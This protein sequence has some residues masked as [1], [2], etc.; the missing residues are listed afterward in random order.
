MIQT[1]F[2]ARVKIQQI[3]NNQLPE[4][5]LDESPKAAEF[6]KQYYISQEF[7][8]ASVDL[9]ENLD[10]YIK[11]DNLTPE[12]IVGETTL[13]QS[14]NS[15]HTSVFVESTKGFPQS[16]GLFKIDDEIIT[17]TGI[18]TNS[19]TGCIRGFSGITDYHDDLKSEELVFSTSTANSH[20]LDSTVINLSSLFLQ[21]I[22]KKLKYSLTPGLENVDFVS[23]LNVGNFIK[24]ARS[25]YESKGTPESFRILFN[26]LFGET[27]KVI[28]LEQFLIKP[29]DSEY[30]RREVVAVEAISGDPTQLEGQSIFK[31]TD[32][33]TSAS[34]SE[35]E[36]ITRSGKTYY[37]LLLFLGY[38][39]TYPT[40]TGTFTITPSSKVLSKVS[41]G[42]SVI[43]VDST[44]G[45]SESGKVYSGNNEITYTN[46]T[47][48]Q[49][50][51]CSGV[52][53]EIPTAAVIRS[54]ETYYGYEN[55][56]LSKKVE[57]RVTGVLSNTVL[58]D[59]NFNFIE[60]D[61]LYPLNLG[62]II[63]N[64]TSKKHLFANTWIYNTS[65]RHQIESRNGTTIT[66]KSPV[67][68]SN[69]KVGDTLE[70]LS[71]NSEIV[72]I[73]PGYPNIEV[74]SITNEKQISTN[75]PVGSIVPGEY[76]IRRKIKTASSSPVPIEFGN[77]NILSDVLNVYDENSEYLYVA[78]NSL[79]SY[80]INS[81][82]FKYTIFG[83][84]GYNSETERYS[85]ITF[86]SEVS[87]ITGDSVYYD[88]SNSSIV[89]LERGS[90]FVEVLS[91]NTSIRLY[92]SASTI[93]TESY[94]T[95]TNIPSGT[96]TLVL[97]SQKSNK[98]SPQKILKK[99][100]IQS[101][102]GDTE[103]NFT[104][105]GAT[106]MLKNGVE[107][108]NYK[109]NDKVYYGPLENVKVLNGGRD[110]D[111][112][113]SPFVTPSFGNALL[114]PVVIGSVKKVYIDP[115]DFN[116]DQI[117]SI[118][119]TG[120][121]GRGASFS[122]VVEKRRREIE[123]DARTIENGGGLDIN[124]E[125][126]VFTT[127]H[128]LIN[129]QEVIY[130]NNNFPEIGVG[131]YKGTNNNQGTT[132]KNG[133]SYFVNTINTQ[134]I[135][136][137]SQ[138]SDYISGINTVGF[139]TI[140]NGGI[141]KLKTGIKNTLTAIKVINGGEGYA[142]RLLRVTS[143]GIST[144]TH[145]INFE[146]HGFLNGELVTY[147]YQ[148][149]AISGLSTSNQYYIL[150]VDS[151]S[152]RVCNAGIGGT[153]TSNYE[154][155]N[156]VKF[157]SKGSGYQIF[158]YP[159][160]SLEVKYTAV[161]LGSTQVL[162]NIVATPVVTGEISQVYAYE[163]G[164][165]YGSTII[166]VHQRPSILVK[167]GSSAQLLPIISN[168]RIIDV[169]IQFGGIEYYSTPELTVIGKGSGATL[170]AIISNN[171]IV[172][173]IIITPGAGYSQN[174]TVIN[175]ES[176]G[177]NSVFQSNV[178]SLTLNSSYKYGVQNQYYR[179]PATEVLVGTNNNLQYSVIGY[180]DT[181]KTGINDGGGLGVG[182]SPI[183]GWS[184]DGN[185]I[186]GPYG[187]SD[188]NNRNSL[189]KEIQPGYIQKSPTN[190]PSTTIFPIDS[191]IEDYEYN[192]T[193][194]LDEYNGRFTK[195]PEF[196][197]GVYA[198]FTTIRR[199]AEGKIVGKFPYFIGN[200]YRS[201]LLTEN[202][203]LDQ[204]FDFNNSS[205]V[206]NTLPYKVNDPFADYD[207]AVESNEIVNQKTVVE[208]VTS[209]SV[210]DLKIISSG[211]DYLIGDE[212]VFDDTGTSGG[213]LAANVLEVK[214]KD[215]I[216]IKTSI[217]SNLNSLLTWESGD[218]IKVHITPYHELS[219]KDNII[220]S[221]LTTESTSLNGFY[222][223]GVSS[224]I[225][226]VAN[227]IPNFTTTVTD[228]YITDIP[229]NVSIGSSIQIENEV[230]SI[231]NSYPT[232]GVLRVSRS[233]S[234][235]AHTQTTSV[236]FLTDS[237]TIDKKIPYFDS[238]KNNKV[239]FNPQQSIGVGTLPGT[240]TYGN[241]NI[242]ITTYNVFIPTQS[243]FLPGH[244]FSNGEEV[245]LRRI[246]GTSIS[247]SN[248]SGGSIFSIL[249]TETE[250]AYVI[251]KS[252]DFIGIVTNIGLTTTTSGVFFLSN[253]SDNYF[254][255]I[256]TNYKQ[257]RADITRV[258]TVV[259]VS[260]SHN[261]NI[262]DSVSLQVNPNISVGIGTSTSVNVKFDTNTQSLIINPIIFTS[263]G[264]STSLDIITISNHNL[265]NGDKVVYN[266]TGTLATGL[267]KA[268]YYVY[269]IDKDRISL[270]QTY[271]DS[272]KNP[273]I[274]V[275][276]T[277]TGS[278]SHSL[279]L[280]NPEI[281][282]I[283]NNNL[284]FNLSDS[285]LQ[286][287]NFKIYYDKKFTKEFL[288]DENTSSFS[289]IGVGTV[290]VTP[291]AT[292]TLN[293]TE[294]T[295]E[296]LYYALEKSGF[297]STS[298]TQV[299]NY[300]EIVT[301][302]SDYNGIYNVNGVGSTNFTI[303]LRN[304][305]ERLSYSQNECDILEYSTKSTN[306]LGGVHRLKLSS[307]G[308]AYRKLPRFDGTKSNTGS[309]LF[310]LPI[311]NQIGKIR[312]E[313]VVNEGFEYASDKTLR[314][315]I[316]IPN[317]L[318]IFSANT[319]DTIQVLDG[320]QNYS[321]APDLIC[322]DSDTGELIDS[323]FIKANLSGS[324]INSVTIENKPR[325]LPTK[326]VTIRAINNT[327]GITINQVQYSSLA[328]I[329]TCILVTPILGFTTSPF[330]NGEKIY[331]EGIQKYDSNGDGFNSSD[332]GYQ[333][334]TVYN[335]F[336]ND[337][338]LEY[339]ISGFTT[340]AGIAKTIQDS[341]SSI[342][343][344]S[345]YPQFQVN[346]VFSPFSIGEKLSS[347]SGFGFIERDLTVVDS[348]VNSVRV[349]GSYSL[350]ENEKIRGID[351]LSE[352]TISSQESTSGFYN[353]NYSNTQNLG[354]KNNIGKL[355][356]D[357]QVISD[358]DYYQ[359][360]SYTVKSSKTWDEI[361]SPVN[362]IV[363]TSGLKNF[364]DLQIEELV[365]FAG[366][367]STESG[368]T[369]IND[370]ISENRVDTIH[371]FDLGIDED[372]SVDSSKFIKFQ[373]IRL[374]DYILC[375]TNLVLE[376]DDI[377]SEF[378][379]VDE[380]KLDFDLLYNSTPIFAKTF[381]PT[382]S[383]VVNL[384]TGRFTIQNHFFSTGEELIYTP[385][386]TGSAGMAIGATA[387][388]LG[389]TTTILPSKVWAIK[390]SNDIFRLSTRPEYAS[391]GIGVTFTS[392]GIGNTHQVEMLKKNEKSIITINNLAQYPISYSAITH[393]L[394]GN[395]GQISTSKTIFG[396]SGITSIFLTDILKIDNEYMRVDNVGFGT[397][398]S[399]PISFSGN[400]PL[401]EVV[402]GFLG[403]N[404]AIHTDTSLSRV[405]RGAYNI[406][407]SK[408]FFA[409][410]PVGNNI[411]LNSS[412]LPEPRDSFTGR[413]F[414]RKN[415]SS[416]LVYDDV[417]DQFT[418]LRQTFTLTTQGIN[419]TGIG[420][421]GGNGIVFINNIFQTPSTLNNPANNYSI[422]ESTGISS[423][424]FSGISSSNGNLFISN[425]DVNQNDLPRGGIIVS[426]GSTSGLGYAPLVGASVTAIVSG[427]SIVSIGI[428]TS[429]T[430]GSGYRNPVSVAV[431][432]STGN[433]AI[434]QAVAGAGG[435]VI[436]SVTNGGTGYTSPQINVS[437]PSYE[438]LPVIGVSRLG[439]GNTTTTGV[440]LLLNVEVGAS[441]TSVGIGSTLFEVTSF[442][443]T[444]P[445]YGFRKGDVFTPVGLV[446]AKGLSS[447][448]NQFQLTVLDT[449]NDSFAAWQFGELDYIDSIKVYQNGIRK[450]F[451]L[452]YNGD[453]L[454]FEIDESNP[455]SQL[456]NFSS[457]LVIFV[458]GVLQK[459][460]DSYQFNGGTSFTFTIAPKPQ[461][462]ISIFFYR[463]TRGEDSEQ[464]DVKETVK[465]GDTLQLFSNN[466]LI[467]QTTTQDP[468]VI[469][470][471]SASDKVETSLYFNQGIDDNLFRPVYWTKQKND[472]ILNGEVVSKV[473][474]S[475]EP[476]IYPTVNII[477][478]VTTTSNEIFV[479]DSSLFN[480]ENV[481]PLANINFDAVI[482]NQISDPIS[483]TITATVSAAGTISSL[484]IT[485]GGSGYSGAGTTIPLLISAPKR[486]AVGIG[487][488]ASAY[489]TI[490]ASGS[491]TTPVVITN[492]GF[493]YTTT[494]TPR[495]ITPIT[496]MEYELIE[497]VT[498][499][500]GFK[501]T[502][503]GIATATGIGVPLAITFKIDP[504]PPAPTSL[505]VG[506]SIY[507]SNTRVGS[508]LTA[509]NTG[510]S[511][512]VSISTSFVNN[513]Y[514]V[515]AYNSS[516]GIVTCNI[517]SNTSTVG[518]AT[519]GSF[520]GNLSWGRLSGFTRS[521]SPISI[522][523]TGYTS[524]VGITTL[525]YGAGLST[526]PI[527][528]RRGFGFKD[529]GAL[530]DRLNYEP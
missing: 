338:K 103:D 457:L 80:A 331:V 473:R 195:T 281:S 526:Y 369:I 78:S 242:G 60:N 69:I 29:S 436:F 118:N 450:R 380:E 321:T 65:T 31:S 131:P 55:G 529:T 310:V 12:V 258:N 437:S 147:N 304:I 514:Q 329:V 66:L 322:V 426:L 443:I 226:G 388:Y 263:S 36:T 120:G 412:G 45:F 482:M 381:N 53:I 430:F 249:S 499:V 341:Y 251:N 465:I 253:G 273:P 135:E 393:T 34:V 52:T 445:G 188:P 246:D 185:P 481:D 384:S 252:K 522:A 200:K 113:N 374:S 23:D 464:V 478:N 92:S 236:Y 153:I 54:N 394:S 38:D 210:T 283:R 9:A 116:I 248:S 396:L 352:A 169:K 392:V 139:T 306:A 290:G 102:T 158:N 89:G 174:D 297:I 494:I 260:T 302:N 22:Y 161:G 327:N 46:K 160:I 201:R 241:Y 270:C 440:G 128:N 217:T 375:R 81:N 308:Y 488:R 307:G 460:G 107:I 6:L 518:I 262:N 484:T 452:Y 454:S 152:F 27:P 377:S 378:S 359:N 508:G 471:I 198:Y 106:G 383:S 486:V 86:G 157:T 358:N 324:T 190:R 386:G 500:E 71:R 527:I 181:V 64:G 402:R 325:G 257:T 59:D 15:T 230:F 336:N 328:G 265:K 37:K 467:T 140:G 35:V 441:S 255:S 93:G 58:N 479:D 438:N 335:Y 189:I 277:A 364:A 79:P 105:P 28:D 395:G 497:G 343:K 296:R 254:Y 173:V 503:G 466:N 40:I 197:N 397:T 292:L 162:S 391:Q 469:Y 320:G 191:F 159:N 435:T 462:N 77:N 168:G 199:N 73:I 221:G 528:Q 171:K 415:Y 275:N 515:H 240:G 409:S 513:I 289:V 213:G 421:S 100:P 142:N 361:V 119:L 347:D 410:S 376:I 389:V 403:S 75:A 146:N 18:T 11:L 332:H 422:T 520:V 447:P 94:E 463:G 211:T 209:G 496:N 137:Y 498:V 506:Y 42:S 288:S 278:G 442:K 51:G 342:I 90:Y 87:F 298:D 228:I 330:S 416:N 267:S 476:Q 202:L 192:E 405:Y 143:S 370:Y 326:P 312:Q 145:T 155:G 30:I 399:G 314:P 164:S 468:R 448:V 108:Y 74:L 423:I 407:E 14:I 148:T 187:Y 299:V 76:D 149:S 154:R 259:S 427:G 84:G 50:L 456:I 180:S 83:S 300:S 350:S 121:N 115:Q 235:V 363:H 382:N 245:T 340:N 272:L 280:I 524:S 291:T 165:D 446:T 43:S 193:G 175:V 485:N 141:H 318:T 269:K 2:E 244:P 25:L 91:G 284:V 101:N 493:G 97:Y 451:P 480:Y 477:R 424:T 24:E 72:I 232:L 274:I 492:P 238:K 47:I 434:V 144:F 179:D 519:T 501:S 483:A 233:A 170:K 16:Y 495:V 305:P 204:S 490:S 167:N 99:F 256:E 311:S 138:F 163:K 196:P 372:I 414:L 222:K 525:G 183:I 303:S 411:G 286:G 216:D 186:Y 32:I 223:I 279:S 509:I 247:V 227:T 366:I 474:R 301:S 214:G 239:Y 56:D 406:V 126:I 354:W 98:I 323:G 219:N 458:N 10:Q 345:N 166:N 371:N 266:S 96:H 207:F 111:V 319:I 156:Y 114:Q 360:L 367:G 205:L 49:F 355:N 220:I 313:R 379:S 523:V 309:G 431:T 133:S 134:T 206:R 444:R 316:S 387:N 177:R 136:L 85:I 125:I 124:D 17:Y 317:S 61:E 203:T 390:E 268:A 472:L 334:F 176:A 123:F 271:T 404:V 487:T 461:D 48:N 491:I 33:K 57:F 231:L 127:P 333:F 420:E 39:D 21:E 261:L 337:G 95:F 20:N 401:V 356:E 419:T 112:I 353:I 385:K 212:L 19:F 293:Y 122:P 502:I 5:I 429:G 510:N 172:D 237:F 104:V 455:D 453:L 432:S 287:Y 229:N 282:V 398:T 439:I 348:N 3:V 234:G 41:V 68:K 521:S 178:R 459:S 109:T 418:G 8:G 150:K 285:S 357:F 218:Q 413:V 215:I 433:G 130:D 129:G 516:T 425:S 511:D 1:G 344:F 63:S 408:I 44:V 517:A 512:I 110:Y 349:N 373:N 428:G 67:D 339:D 530:D 4:F 505:Q 449:F 507:V 132:L 117:V 194:D 504:L 224:H 70:I 475:I 368:I 365:S 250:K 88:Y 400:V 294:K 13:T 151:N 26:I 225:A 346:Q 208:S 264:I 276:I 417:S 82:I 362:S 489:A 315:S 295:P 351:S 184:Y 62:E 182:H 7:Q 470:D 243:I